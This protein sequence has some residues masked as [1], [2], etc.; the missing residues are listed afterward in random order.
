MVRVLRKEAVE[1]FSDVGRY[2]AHV[3]VT[4][5]LGADLVELN[6]PKGRGGSFLGE[7]AFAQEFD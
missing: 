1:S 7:R 3:C 4:R 2:S 6:P 5:A